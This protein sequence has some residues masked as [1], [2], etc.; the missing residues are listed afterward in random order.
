MLSIIIDKEFN[1]ELI[2]EKGDTYLKKLL[3]FS[4]PFDLQNEIE[5]LPFEELWHYALDILK[6]NKYYIHYRFY[7]PAETN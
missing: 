3:R 7:S 2:A 5:V 1:Y 4:I 6:T